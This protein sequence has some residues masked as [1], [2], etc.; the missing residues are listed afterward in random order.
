MRGYESQ[1]AGIRAVLRVDRHSKGWAMVAVTHNL[2]TLMR[3][4]PLRS[5]SPPRSVSAD[6]LV[7][8]PQSTAG[9][10]HKH[11]FAF[12]RTNIELRVTS[13]HCRAL[14]GQTGSFLNMAP[15]VVLSQ[16]Y[17]EKADIFSLGCCLFEVRVTVS[18]MAADTDPFPLDSCGL[19]RCQCE[20][21]TD[22][23]L[24]WPICTILVSN[25]GVAM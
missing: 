9:R 22:L 24:R 11:A 23:T 17:D 4:C 19:T 16:P 5:T 20:S 21:I 14:A 10:R 8:G 12:S 2:M 7:L 1:A 15:E 3:D 13:K 25:E 18:V 6:T